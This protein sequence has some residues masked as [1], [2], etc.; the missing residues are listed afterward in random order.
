GSWDLA[1][2]CCATTRTSPPAG[3]SPVAR[4]AASTIAARSSPGCTIGTPLRPVIVSCA[5]IGTLCHPKNRHARA[6][7]GHPRKGCGP[8]LVDGL[9]QP[10]HDLFGRVGPFAAGHPEV[11]R[12]G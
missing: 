2:I 12:R 3:A 10:G 1:T 6:S 9:A 8:L 7:P 5:D 11:L 4:Y